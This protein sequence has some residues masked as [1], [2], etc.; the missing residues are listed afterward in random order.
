MWYRVVCNEQIPGH[1]TG[2][3]AVD[4]GNVALLKSTHMKEMPVELLFHPMHVYRC[5]L[6]KLFAIKITFIVTI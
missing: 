5:I 3:H 6:S 2:V 1:L 4:L